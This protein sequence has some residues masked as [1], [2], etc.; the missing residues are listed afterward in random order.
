MINFATEKSKQ[1]SLEH[2]KRNQNGSNNNGKF[3]L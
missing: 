1:Q 3:S 2:L